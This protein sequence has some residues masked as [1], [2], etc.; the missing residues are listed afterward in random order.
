MTDV[1]IISLETNRQLT[2]WFIAQDPSSIVFTPHHEEWSGGA[3]KTVAD[4]DREV[5]IVKFIYPGGD[6]IVLAED[7]NTRHFDFIV[8]AEYDAEIDIWD[9]FDHSNNHYVIEY[10]FPYNGYEVKVGGSSHG[11]APDYG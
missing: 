8:V 2:S 6:G 11:K 4:P 3:K 10:V 7:H 9:S 1:G 5:Q